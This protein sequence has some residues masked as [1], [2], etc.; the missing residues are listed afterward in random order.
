MKQPSCSL[1]LSVPLF[2]RA[3]ILRNVVIA[4][5]ILL[6]AFASGAQ[7]FS[8]QEIAR[9]KKQARQ[10]TIIRDNWGIPHIYGK[11]DADAVFGLLYAQCEDD[12]KR[13]EM[14]YIEKLGRTAE[15]KG[16]SE[17][18]NDLLIRMVIDSSE[19]IKDYRNSPGW[20]R[21]LMDAYADGINYYLHTHPAT[22][23][24]LLK[25][26]QPWYALLWTDGSIGAID[27]AGISVNELRSFYGTAPGITALTKPVEF[28][29]LPGGSNGFAIAPARTASGNAIL[30]INPHVTF[31]FRP[32]VA[33]QSEEGLH[34]Y[35]AVTWGQFFVYQGFNEH[36]G[37]MHTSSYSDVADAYSEKVIQKNGAFFYEY[38][39][40]LKPVRQKTI[41]VKYL[42][43]GRLV[44]KDITTYYTHHGPVM[45]KRNGQWISVRANNRDIKG[46]IQSWQRTK[47]T[48]LEAFTKTM[49]LLAN[50]SNNT[51]Y[52]DDKGNIGYWHGNFMPKRDP[53]LNWTKPVDG[54]TSATEWKGLH[55][56][57]ELIQVH[58]PSS[59]WIQNC[60]STPFTVSGSSSPK[61]GDF[62]VYMAPAGENFRG[63]NAAKLLAE[64]KGYTI[65][66]T[67]HTGYDTHL[68]A[69]DVLVPALLKAYETNTTDTAYR[70]LAEPIKTLA[71][72]DRNSAENSIATTLAVEWGQKI[73]PLA[74]RSNGDNDNADQVEKTQRFAASANAQTLLQP[75]LATIDE[76]SKKM[77]SWQIP[78]GAI[79]RYQRLSGDLTEKFD[80]AEPSISCGFAASTWGCL[81]SF[82]SRTYA[83][84]NKRYGYNGNSFI[85][86]VEFGKKI[87]AKSLLAGG[88]SGDITSK[89]FG[90]QAE[91]YTKGRFKDVLFYKEDVVKHAERTYHPGE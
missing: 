69:F 38:D 57:K 47:A 84:T 15:V 70:L 81:P 33:V 66:K 37:W 25:R 90:D 36:C 14:N 64:N 2:F 53:K 54:S 35:G 87:K 29:P 78:W 9:W 6:G 4:L 60:N 52:A 3:G 10:I 41:T 22:K 83:G 63:V 23:P 48:S 28:D 16:E 65:D 5:P 49:E 44:S 45:A 79:N 68:A 27:V 12:F 72:W 13:V 51:V 17:L 77:G 20:L 55:S 11:T 80:D 46:L 24:A 85:C 82:V 1:P 74:Q 8:P 7:P 31:Y 86:A 73:W 50:T 19:A 67:I 76:L 58:N 42:S 40:Q 30:Y 88:E 39:K 61:K 62:P 59:G 89:H 91:M 75:L 21:K 71:A 56:L 32:E 34:A 26:F 18:Y 43:N